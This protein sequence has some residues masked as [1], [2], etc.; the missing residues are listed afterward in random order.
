MP[1]Q[2]P[3]RRLNTR[4]FV[5]GLIV[6][7]AVLALGLAGLSL[8]PPP[9]FAGLLVALDEARPA[10]PTPLPPT[11]T[12]PRGAVPAGQVGVTELAQ[13]QGGSFYA[14]GAGFLLRLDSGTVVG[15]TTAHSV[16][17]GNSGRPLERIGFSVSDLSKVL[18][19]FDTLYGAPG[20]P[21]AGD[22]LADDYVLLKM[23]DPTPA[24]DPDLILQPDSRGAPQPGERVAM[25]NGRGGDG[26]GSP[27]ELR[28]T[29][30]SADESGVWVLM[31]ERFDAGG[32]SGSPLMSDTTGRVVG[33]LITGTYRW[34]H[35]LLGFHPI[36]SIV[37]H[38][39]AAAEF[40]KIADYLR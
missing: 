8:L 13:Y 26:Q 1:S 38:A 20:V 9:I 3:A 11:I 36:G 23:P 2:R 22:N 6:F 7:L 19:P 24:L 34:G 29:V 32:M 4:L 15:V 40:L 27:R 14:V 37:R 39:G 17:L 30:Q 12:A 5:R 18:V 10:D 21:R 25:F 28:G 16:D 31:D 35:T 33:M